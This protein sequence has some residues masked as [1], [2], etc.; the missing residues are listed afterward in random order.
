MKR[1]PYDKGYSADSRLSGVT[2]AQNLHASVWLAY[3]LCGGLCFSVSWHWLSIGL[4]LARSGDMG[5]V[6]A[7]NNCTLGG[8]AI[9]LAQGKLSLSSV[10]PLLNLSLLH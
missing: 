5:K 2:L 8:Q 9:P 3:G 7:W 4:A 1:R 10:K 6:K